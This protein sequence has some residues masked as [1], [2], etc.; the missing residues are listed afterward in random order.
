ME[1]QL[2]ITLPGRF[3]S[4]ETLCKFVVQSA[5]AAGLDPSDIYAVQVSVDEAFSN[6]VEHAY[7]GGSQ[8]DVECTCHIDDE[9][10]VVMLRDHGMPF[11]PSAVKAPRLGVCLDD[12]ESGGLGLYFMHRLMDEVRFEFDPESGN[13]VTLVKRKETSS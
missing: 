3:Q 7:G 4:L 6:I 8:L 5:E 10:L 11:D 2:T 9:N 13:V 12:R 1:S